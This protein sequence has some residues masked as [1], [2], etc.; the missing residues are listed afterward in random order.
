MLDIYF[1]PEKREDDVTVLINMI[2]SP[3]TKNTM[4]V[5]IMSLKS[6]VG[7]IY[8][9]TVF[10]PLSGMHI[11]TFSYPNE[12]NYY[13]SHGYPAHPEKVNDYTCLKCKV[14]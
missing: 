9:E 10:G 7:E 4:T 13:Q 8:S 12:D 5:I 3:G 11:C 6:I 14:I 2:S 1:F